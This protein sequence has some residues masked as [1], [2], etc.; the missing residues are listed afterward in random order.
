MKK[1]INFILSFMTLFALASCSLKQK[2]S[3]PSQP[4]VEVT[5]IDEHGI[6]LEDPYQWMEQ[7]ENQD[8]LNQWLLSE[9]K[10]THS[11][12]VEHPLRE[13]L[14]KRA[15]DLAGDS[16]GVYDLRVYGDNL[17]Y[18]RA[19]IGAKQ[20]NLMYRDINGKDH[21][22]LDMQ[23][24]SKTNGKRLNLNDYSPSMDGKF[25]AYML[26]DS[27][28][29]ITTIKFMEVETGR[30]FADEIEHIW[31]EFPPTWLPDN[32]GVF[33]TQ[34]NPEI[35]TN[36]TLDP[37]QNMQVYLHRFGD[38]TNND[39]HILGSQLDNGITIESQEFPMVMAVTKSNQVLGYAGGA[40][41]EMRLFSSSLSDL[42]NKKN[43]WKSVAD[44]DDLV[45]RVAIL[46]DDM[47]LLHSKNKPNG[48]LV[49]TPINAPSLA[50]AK[51]I[52]PHSDQVI[53]EISPAKDELY[54][55]VMA[56]GFHKLYQLGINDLE[57]K[58]INLPF[59]GRLNIA[60]NTEK[61][62]AFLYMSSWTE[63]PEY[64]H[65]NSDNNSMKQLDF[66]L[67]K[68]LRF[69]DYIA[70]DIEVP[71]T[72]GAL[73]PMTI[74]HHKTVKKDGNNLTIL[75]GYGGYG[76]TIMP[77]FSRSRLAWLEQGGV[78]AYVNV[79]GSGAKGRQWH[80][81]GKGKN[82][83]N[84]IDDFNAAAAY[85]NHNK[86]SSHKTLTAWGASMGG[87]LV[88][89]AITQ[90]PDLY[91]AALIDVAVINTTRFHKGINGENQIAELGDPKNKADYQHLLAIDAYQNLKP[92]VNYPAMMFSLGLNDNRV[93]PWHT[94]K[95][96]A[97]L[98]SYKNQTNPFYLRVSTSDGHGIGVS[99]N[100]AIESRVDRWIFALSSAK[101]P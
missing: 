37:V 10:M 81:D 96:A 25:L 80:Q 41:R 90:R 28:A 4:R 12:L 77:F 50:T 19:E 98:K 70:T 47:Y 92:E 60:T 101:Q 54:I 66:G 53:E 38:N 18:L 35:F 15:L 97:K 36:K 64:F 76:S 61:S 95:F 24:L 5:I 84:G 7:I 93:A 58:K 69:S 21:L 30:V 86:Y 32:S 74:I 44:Y 1:N 71:S 82:K 100:N 94:G 2:S 6:R 45:S 78:L 68:D 65:Y 26:S 29:E 75:Y 20:A 13:Q 46:N 42:L 39:K 88:S 14:L 34:M 99:V 72:G 49:S 83:Q 67:P 43:P 11:K 85:L 22:L 87:V 23:A 55:K 91:A 52:V 51:I 56:S 8:E 73:V 9:G 27:G 89:N 40:R 62:G 3:S 63:S 79:R 17:F 33:Y 48:E 16:A 57:P 31:S 59:N